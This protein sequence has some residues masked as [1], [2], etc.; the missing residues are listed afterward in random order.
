VF[1]AVVILSGFGLK[2]LNPSGLGFLVATCS[3]LFA[4]KYLKFGEKSDLIKSGLL[5]GLTAIFRHDYAIYLIVPI[6]L[7]VLFDIEKKEKV[8]SLLLVLW[9][10]LPA[11]VIYLILGAFA[12]FGNMIDQLIVFPLTKFSNVR[13][14]PFPL[15]WEAKYI[16]DSVSNYFYNVWIAV[17]F[18]VPPVVA[19][20]NYVFYR[21][22]KLAPLYIYYG[23]L[24]LLFYNQALNRSDYSHLLPSLL[25]SMPLLFSFVN[26]VQ[27][28]F[29]RRTALVILSV[30]LFLVPLAKKANYTK[31][32]YINK[33][34]VK[35]DLPNLNHVYIVGATDE[36][37]HYVQD[38]KK[39]I[40]KDKPTFIGLQ[41]MS[42]IEVNDVMMYYV[43]GIMPHTKYH[44]LHPGI[45]DTRLYQKEIL[46]EL[47]DRNKY[48]LLLRIEPER[49][50]RGSQYFR[51]NI[52]NSYDYVIKTHNI[53]LMQNKKYLPHK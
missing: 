12:G 14:L 7:S 11:V 15:V 22:H 39:N 34:L 35:T 16:S 48:A 27:V 46:K 2:Y 32:Y 43:L 1:V 51:E 33:A 6:V 20:V 29:N 9:C 23:L 13:S 8:R 4:L 45:A 40:L 24:V 42:S 28:S 17:M 19:I 38:L 37:Y 31:K 3:V 52:R 30:L 44:E 26:A 25:L 49:R 18:L 36:L 47:A 41:D 50:Y 10:V 53:E 21:K 5:I